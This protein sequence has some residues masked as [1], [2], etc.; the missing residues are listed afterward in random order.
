MVVPSTWAVE[1][2]SPFGCSWTAGGR[3]S[4]NR[5]LV[6][7][8]RVVSGAQPKDNLIQAAPFGYFDQTLSTIV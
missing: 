3:S 7:D 8:A 2:L 5:Q 1:Y 4:D 6:S